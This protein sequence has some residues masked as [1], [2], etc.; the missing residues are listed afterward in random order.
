[1]LQQDPLARPHEDADLVIDETGERKDG[2][3]TDHLSYQYLGSIGRI[4]NG[5][6]SVSSLWA[7]EKAYH[8]L[9]VE[10]Y[11]PAKPLERGN[12]DPAFPT[13]PEIATELVERAPEASIPF[14]V[15]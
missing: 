2:I 8:P 13:K 14:S 7:D 5:I 1:M 11:T 3:K 6:V 12:G 9:H 4:A 10:P 15:R